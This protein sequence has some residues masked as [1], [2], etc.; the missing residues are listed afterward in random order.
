M[1]TFCISTQKSLNYDVDILNLQQTAHITDQ[2]L[3]TFRLLPKARLSHQFIKSIQAFPCLISLVIMI[4]CWKIVEIAMNTNNPI[5]QTLTYTPSPSQCLISL[6]LFF[7]FYK[8]Y[9]FEGSFQILYNKTKGSQEIVI[10][11]LVFNL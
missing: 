4:L 11:H 2:V 9:Y 1:Y 6:L 10:D 5:F 7:F 3:R 8:Q